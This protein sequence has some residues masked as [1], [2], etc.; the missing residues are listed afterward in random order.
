MVILVDMMP[1]YGNGEYELKYSNGE[2]KIDV[3]IFEGCAKNGG[4][5][6]FSEPVEEPTEPD[7]AEP[8]VIEPSE[9]TDESE[10]GNEEDVNSE[11]NLPEQGIVTPSEA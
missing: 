10:Q 2:K 5:I 1:V 11:E 4:F 7:G 6:D 8:D 9:P 3:Y